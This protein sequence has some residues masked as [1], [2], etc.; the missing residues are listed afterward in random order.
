MIA[1]LAALAFVVLLVASVVLFVRQMRFGVAATRL[2]RIIQSEDGF[3]REEL[4]R[5]ARG[6]VLPQVALP[7]YEAA[8]RVVDERPDDWRAWFQ[9]GVALGD[10]KRPK[11]ARNAVRRAVA[12]ERADQRRR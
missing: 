7:R 8:R 6:K 12:L 10:M 2:A 9:L 1:D 5:D 3:D 11:D 4:E